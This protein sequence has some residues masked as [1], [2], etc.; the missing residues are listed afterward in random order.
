MDIYKATNNITEESYIGYAIYGME[1]RKERHKSSA[2]RGDGYYFHRAIKKYG[3][4]NFSWVLLEHGVTDFDILNKL[5]I[6]WIEEFD[7]YYNGYNLTKGGGGALGFYPSEETRKKL[8]ESLKGRKYSEETKRKLSEANKGHIVTEETRRKISEAQKGHTYNRGRIIGSMP[9]EARKKISKTMK[10]MPK[11]EE[12]KRKMSEAKK[13]K[14]LS[15]EHKQ[16]MRKPKS[17]EHRKK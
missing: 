12:T 2:N 17:K 8:S 13:G 7:T 6:Y 16:N 15:E 5:E 11:S 1:E 4:D 14:K 10:G 9:E 3:W